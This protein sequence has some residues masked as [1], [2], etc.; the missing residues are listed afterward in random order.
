MSPQPSAGGHNSPPADRQIATSNAT[1]NAFLGNRGQPS[2]VTGAPSKQPS[3]P[4]ITRQQTI[5]PAPQQFAHT[6][7]PSPAPSDEPSPAV[8]NPHD[9]PN[10]IPATLPAAQSMVSQAPGAAGAGPS[11]D[12]PVDVPGLR[13]QEQLNDGSDHYGQNHSPHLANSQLRVRISASLRPTTSVESYTSPPIAQAGFQPAGNHQTVVSPT[14]GQGGHN[15]SAG[16]PNG[17]P[18]TKRRRTER[19]QAA[20]LDFGLLAKS[21][22]HHINSRGGEQAFSPEIEKPRLQLL[23][24]ACAKRDAFFL[25]LHQLYSVWSASPAYAHRYLNRNPEVLDRSFAVVETILKR[26]QLVS[27]QTRTFFTAFPVAMIN[28]HMPQATGYMEAI[29]HVAAFLEKLANNWTQLMNA[30]VERRFPFLVDELVTNLG[31]YSPVLQMIFFTACRRRLGVPDGPLASGMEQLFRQDQKDHQVGGGHIQALPPSSEVIKRRNTSL[32]Q[33]YLQIIHSATSQ[34]PRMTTAHP[35]VLSPALSSPQSSTFPQVQNPSFAAAQSRGHAQDVSQASPGMFTYETNGQIPPIFASHP[36][37]GQIQRAVPVLA[38]N[39]VQYSQPVSLPSQLPTHATSSNMGGNQRLQWAGD[40]NMARQ[41]QQL[42]NE[43]QHRQQLLLSQQQQQQQT[44]QQQSQQV[45]ASAPTTPIAQFHQPGPPTQIHPQGR[46][47]QHVLGASQG[48]APPLQPVFVNYAAGVQ[49]Q[50]ASQTQQNLNPRTPGPRQDDRLLPPKDTFIARPDWAYDTSDKKSIMMS[51]HQ[52]HVRSP[53]RVMRI[54]KTERAYQAVKALPVGPTLITVKHAV[55]TLFFTVSDEQ[56]ALASKSVTKDGELLPFADHFSGS[57]RWR[58][59]CCKL[60]GPTSEQEWVTLDVKW[61]Q[62]IWIVCNGTPLEIRRQ[63]HNGKDL[64]VELTDVIQSGQNRVD[65]VVSDKNLETAQNR[66]VA[67]ELLET[68]YHSDIL[69]M[70]WA[71]NVI[72]EEETLKTIQKR[73]AGP[74]DDDGLIFE[75]SDLSID[76]A[77][78]FS[79]VIFTVPARGA[80]CT[81]MECFDLETWL[82]TRPSKAVKKCFHTLVKCECPDIS[83]PSMPD[84]WK[85]PIC[86]KD[87][88][89]YSLRIDKFLLKVR[90]QLEKENKLSAKSM[91]VKQDGTWTAVVEEDDDVDTD[92]EDQPRAGSKRHTPATTARKQPEIEVIELD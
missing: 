59:R 47:V 60:S 38:S 13:P 25:A 28:H 92:D 51:L 10:P 15:Q 34:V 42:Q 32:I 74:T 61:P 7:L 26:N 14:Q 69:N 41:L 29:R 54:P 89:P 23:R 43:Q 88:R 39:G 77:D 46:A 40:Q 91:R 78:P 5:Q 16:T 11:N 45:W 71:N 85:C 35:L 17:A 50:T 52:A 81:H 30:A 8:S 49:P 70:L 57:L 24:D 44:A 53:K 80:S 83:E 18:A 12:A 68:L 1:V 9:S 58:L 4:T 82:D 64:A 86:N 36:S 6:V 76:L 84:R 67:V 22:D 48:S 20:F 56:L 2:W 37:Q 63:S 75:A 87:A 27:P 55:Q 79:S 33:N 65:I 3:R 90:E 72:P 66:F 73:L 21:I 62:S 31:C 19:T